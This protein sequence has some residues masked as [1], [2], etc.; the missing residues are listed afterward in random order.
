MSVE[1]PKIVQQIDIGIAS[2]GETA[3][4]VSGA[5]AICTGA[6]GAFFGGMTKSG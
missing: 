5:D 3:G 2:N 1:N 4:T 6:P